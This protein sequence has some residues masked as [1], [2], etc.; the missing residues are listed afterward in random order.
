MTNGEVGQDFAG[1]FSG[2]IE[3]L[4]GPPTPAADPKVVVGECH[5]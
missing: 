3:L 1:C 5:R 2:C 4:E